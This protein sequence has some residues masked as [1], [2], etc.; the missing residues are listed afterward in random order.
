MQ[1]TREIDYFRFLEK[2]GVKSDLIPL[3]Y[4][5][6]ETENECGYVQECFLDR[7]HCGVYDSVHELHDFLTKKCPEFPTVIAMLAD[8]KKELIAKNIIISDLH[9]MNILVV[10]KNK[11][12]RLKV[13]DG[14]GS[15]EAI[16]LPKYF[17]FFGKLKIHRQWKKFQQRY[18]EIEF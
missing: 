18:P 13:I 3:Y 11:K 10:T 12:T 14:W 4:E 15:P 17:R 6:F 8:M 2:H 16:P 7:D 1:I 9:G 5:T